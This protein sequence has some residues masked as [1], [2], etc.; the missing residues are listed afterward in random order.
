VSRLIPDGFTV[1]KEYIDE[2]EQ[3]E[4]GFHVRYH[5]ITF[6][7][8]GR[9]YGARIWVDSPEEA[10]ITGPLR[11]HEEESQLHLRAMARYLRENEGVR[12]VLTVG[13]SGGFQPIE[14]HWF[15][16]DS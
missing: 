16:I 1:R 9:V 8:A 4:V 10:D 12:K 3:D 13:P 2:G 7:F 14:E 15:R 6:D 5:A 11:H